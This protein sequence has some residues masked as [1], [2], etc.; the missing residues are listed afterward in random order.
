MK[1]R[2]ILTAGTLVVLGACAGSDQSPSHPH[3]DA[4]IYDLRSA[5]AILDHEAEYTAIAA[6]YDAIQDIDRA[7]LE[8]KHAAV[9]TAEE[10]EPPLGPA[11]NLDYPGR[12]HRARD[13]VVAA[14]FE[15][16]FKEDNPNAVE[17]RDRARHEVD[18]VLDAIDRTIRARQ[19]AA[20]GS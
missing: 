13:L 12:L 9:D 14:R 5:R 11:A 10:V 6:Q 20:A 18:G 4:A 16:R 3:Y 1:P 17:Y 7:V 8:M 2:E 19:V 15:L